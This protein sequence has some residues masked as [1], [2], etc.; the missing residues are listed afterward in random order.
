MFVVAL[1]GGPLAKW[2][3]TKKIP[4]YIFDD[5]AGNPSQQPRMGL[6]Y[7]VFGQLALLV[8]LG[9]V[10]LS[11]QEIREAV[12]FLQRLVKRWDVAVQL[13]LL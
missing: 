5:A 13:I 10:R 12:K 7:S 4:A 1:A 6:G 3:Q 11:D 2:A 9:L 8:K